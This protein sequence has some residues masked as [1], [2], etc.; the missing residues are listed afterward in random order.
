MNSK[1]TID[2]LHAIIAEEF[3]RSV[4]EAVDYQSIREIVN[5]ASKLLAAVESFNDSASTAMLNAVTPHLDKLAVTLEDMVASPGSYVEKQRNVV[6]KVS[7]RPVSN[8]E[9]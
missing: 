4:N 8:K 6:K 1:I 3:E 2:R 5:A 9:E 7:L